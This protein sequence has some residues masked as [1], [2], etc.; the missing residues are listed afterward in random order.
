MGILASDFLEFNTYITIITILFF[1]VDIK[2]YHTYL[3][4]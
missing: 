2:S 1:V 4:Q 3:G